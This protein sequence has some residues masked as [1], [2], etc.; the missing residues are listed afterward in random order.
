MRILLLTLL[1]GFV[2]SKVCAQD[3]NYWTQQAGTRSHFMGG[4]VVAG[5]DDT[6]AGYYNP[7]RLAWID[8]PALSVSATMYQIDRYFIEDGA[9]DER[10]LDALNW[11]VVPSLVS[12]I[13]LFDFAPGHA[14]GHTI[15]ARHYYSNSVSARREANEN[16]INDT[17]SPGNED[18]TAQITADID[19]QEYWIGLSW[20][21]A[22]TD[23]L[24]IG[25]SNFAGLRIEKLF[26]DISARAVWFNGTAFEAASIDNETYVNYVDLRT[27]LKAGIALDLGDFKAGATVTTESI[28]L[29]GQGTV[30]RTIEIL[31]IDPDADG[32]GASLVLN[33]RQEGR[34]TSFRSPWSFALGLEYNIPVSNT[35]IT[36][37]VEWFLPVGAYTVIQ[38]KSDPFLQG[39]G[40]FGVGSNDFLR[41]RDTRQGALN[42]AVGVSQ[43]FGDWII[44][45]WS[46]HWGFYTDFNVDVSKTD[47]AIYLGTT[48]WDLYHG[49][50]GI[51]IRTDKSEFGLGIHFTLGSDSVKQNIN[52]DNPSDT[53]VLLGESGSTRGMYW[54]LGI[55]AG[56]T[57]FF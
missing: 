51:T 48:D 38:P 36:A 42:V 14:F 31:N 4:S 19:L 12:G 24:S 6:S 1:I 7:A 21:W 25:L 33:D 3:Q 32:N 37:S 23:F 45:E 9:G 2:S 18:Y 5:V 52:L 29:W 13:H 22:P 53:R 55:V 56:Y 30:S 47:S 46:G 15:M 49:I 27:F 28:N 43:V 8:N 40:A 20:S 11:R 39:A 16:V 35:R 10:D 17:Q 34:S 54:A 57:Y 50:T 41:V 26:S 44:G